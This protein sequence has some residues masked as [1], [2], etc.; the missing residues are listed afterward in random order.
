MFDSGFPELLV[1][2]FV[3]SKSDPVSPEGFC[4]GRQQT[5]LEVSDRIADTWNVKTYSRRTP[6]CRFRNDEP[7]AFPRCRMK[8]N[9]C[10]T[11]K[12]MLLFFRDI[13]REFDA[14]DLLPLESLPVWS[15]ANNGQYASRLLLDRLPTSP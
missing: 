3:Q 7:P 11:H 8:K 5:G 4:I 15:V 6:D 9:P 14:F 13:A 12:A 2:V 1:E 10:F